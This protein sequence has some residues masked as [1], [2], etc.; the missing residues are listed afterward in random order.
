MHV[1]FIHRAFPAQFGQLALELTRH[2]GWKCSALVEHLSRCPEPS[3]EML[4]SVDLHQLPRPADADRSPPWPQTYG[5]ALQR[6]HAAAEAVRAK[7]GLRPDLVVGHGGLVPT[8]FLREVLS[9]PVIDYCEYWFAPAHRDLTYRVDLPPVEPAPFF[10]RC[11]N[12]ATLVSLVA[13]DAGY[14]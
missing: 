9:C 13:C 11:I 10:P 8:L 4:Q 1:L 7:P 2:S 14:A 3:P 5:Q 6:A 12:A